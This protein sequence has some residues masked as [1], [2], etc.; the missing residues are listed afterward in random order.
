MSVFLVSFVFAAQGSLNR[1]SDDA[2]IGIASQVGNAG[3]DGQER[4]RERVA[5]RNGE[6]V[7]T[8]GKKIMISKNSEDNCMIEDD[9]SEAECELEVLMEESEDETGI[10]TK[11]FGK[12]SNGRNAEIKIM[13]ST[14]SATAISR[15]RI[16]NCNESNNCTIQLKETRQGNE[17]R[18]AYEVQAQRHT[19]LLW[20]FRKKMEVKAEIDA[21]TGE[22]IRVKKPWWAFLASETVEEESTENT[23]AVDAVEI[24]D[25]E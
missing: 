9:E 15:L 13:P 16:R 21:E 12:L 8:N 2:P 10:K 4:A 11:L 22:L 18:L 7:G 1:L 24:E 25:S 17:T 3:E 20:M 6:I 19:K 5:V 14:A 23:D